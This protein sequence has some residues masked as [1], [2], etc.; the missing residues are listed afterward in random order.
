[1]E[2]DF[3]AFKM[4]PPHRDR[5]I[6][7]LKFYLEQAEARLLGQFSDKE[8]AA[9][10]AAKEH[11]QATAHLFNPD[12][13]D[14]SEFYEAATD[15]S[16]DIYQL[17][18]EMEKTTKLSIA[19]SIYHEW[20]KQLRDWLIQEV[21]RWHKIKDEN[22]QRGNVENQIWKQNFHGIMDLMSVLIPDLKDRDCY[23]VLDQF[24]LVVNVFKHGDGGAFDD[25]KNNHTEYL[26]DWYQ[27]G[28][29]SCID[30]IDYSSLNISHEQIKALVSAIEQ[31]WT[32][33]PDQV[34]ASEVETLPNWFE[35]AFDKDIENIRGG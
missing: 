24:R 8:E 4:W 27:M 31:F 18:A 1:M 11:L 23:A 28:T 17:L 20:D 32:A 22:G 10:A 19:A 34:L 26:K 21:M 7:E 16:H 15:H 2:R 35:K 5:L 25:L 29:P 13:H 9:D 3:V 30:Y 6:Y 12:R 33:V 14:G